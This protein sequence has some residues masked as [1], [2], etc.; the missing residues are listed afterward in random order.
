MPNASYT[1]EEIVRLGRDRYER[2]IRHQ[3]EPQQDGKFLALDV[4]TGEYAIGDEALD[5]VRPLRAR[6][7]DAP[8]YIHR[9][10]HPAAYRL[11]GRVVIESLA[12]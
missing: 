12:H 5:A 8:I 4:E 10:G 9:I 1:V 3:V 6:R 2:D 11:G 7:P